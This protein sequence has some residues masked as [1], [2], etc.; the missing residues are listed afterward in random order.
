MRRKVRPDVFPLMLIIVL[1]GLSIA[2]L[3]SAA[4]TA[5]GKAPGF[6]LTSIDGAAFSLNDFRGKVVLLDLMATWCPVCKEEMSELVQVHEA[7]PEVVIITISVDPTET[8]EMLREFKETYGAEWLFARDT[9]HI[10]TNYRNFALPTFVVID[11]A[12]YITLN[13]AEAMTAAE[14]VAEVDRAYAGDGEAP[15]ET[16]P[17][18]EAEP[19]TVWGLLVLAFLTGLFSFFSPCAFP[20]M[21]G[22]ISYYLGRYEGGPT[23]SGS[24]KAGLAAATGINGIFAVIGGAV[25]LGGVAVKSYV[26]YFA[27]VVGIAIILLGV[28]MLFGKSELF[29][30]FGSLLTASSAK[31]G[32]GARYSGLFLYGVGYGLAAMGCQAPIFIALIFAGLAAGGAL[33]AFIVFLAFSLGMGCMMLVLSVIVGTAKMKLLERIRALI[34]YINRACGLILILVGAYFL[35]EIL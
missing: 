18:E 6:N 14:F 7:R 19:A 20:L 11:P 35:L 29:T 33:E 26:S 12:G 13:T 4:E 30:R 5:Y 16:E 23:F 34:P 17:E 9:D 2:V 32:G 10:W 15:D 28:V 22:Y 1:L 25:A 21:P 31:F 24:V 27:P 3:P 8:N